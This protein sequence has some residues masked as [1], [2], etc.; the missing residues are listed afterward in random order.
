MGLDLLVAERQAFGYAYSPEVVDDLLAGKVTLLPHPAWELPSKITWKEDPFQDRN[1]TFQFHMLRWLDPLRRAASK[2]GSERA[3]SMWFRHVRDWV[4]KNPPQRPRSRWAWKDMS[5][6]IRALQLCLAAPLVHERSPEE[7]PWLENTIR[8]HA[9]HLADPEKQGVA[10]HALHQAEALF[11]C[12]RVLGDSTLWELALARMGALILEQYD[13]QGVNAEASI[14]YHDSNFLWW[15]KTL[16]RVDA[17]RLP[18]PPDAAR[19]GLAPEQ[20][21]HATRP[22]GTLVMI[23][24]TDPQAPKSVRSPFVQ[25]VTSDG[26]KG[27]APDDLVKVYEAGYVFGRSGWGSSTRRYSEE[28]FFSLRFGPAH[29]VHG[30]PDGG[31]ATYSASTVNWVVDP[32]KYEYGSSPARKH[33]A[34]RASHSL[35][36]IE[37]RDPREGARVEL[38]RQSH[39]ARHHEFV[40]ADDSFPGISLMRRVIHSV[41]GEYLVVV[42]HVNSRQEITACQRWQLGPEVASS[43]D[44]QRAELSA[45]DHRAALMFAG[46]AVELSE[47]TAQESP[48]DG[49]VSTGWKQKVPAT[50]ITARKSGTSFRIITVLAAGVGC[51]PTMSS[52]RTPEPAA[53]GLRITTGDVDELIHVGRDEVSFP[54]SP[55][56]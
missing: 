27:T 21:A 12:G 28:S 45:G 46:T 55:P 29:R 52:F 36:S 33:F 41:R 8:T 20:I 25:F 5:D 43:T 51:A 7:L 2:D 23:G 11:V 34:S 26:S 56:R 49:W 6:G 13:E 15:E 18:R 17:E 1:W 31:S 48:F 53:F 35:V 47:V 37:G 54:V 30:H 16:R 39:S 10:N 3:Y 50:A 24:D 38:H 40:L 22:D 19:H 44:G 4:E 9:A 14:S 32:G 42:D